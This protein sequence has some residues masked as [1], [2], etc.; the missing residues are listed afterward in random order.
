MSEEFLQPNWHV[1]LIHYPLGLLT[2]GILVELLAFLWRGSSV[3]AAARWMILIGALLCIPTITAGLYAFRDVVTPEP[4]SLDQQWHAVKAGSNWSAEQWHYMMR[5]IWFAAGGAALCIL[6]AF[7]WLSSSDRGRA[8]LHWPA[9]ILVL[10][11]FVLLNVGAWYSGE[12]VYRFGTSVAESTRPA[13]V[14]ET[15]EK[16]A[17]TTQPATAAAAVEETPRRYER[18]SQWRYYFPPVQVHVLLA[19]LTVAF[20]LGAMGATIRRWK[21]EAEVEAARSAVAAQRI[22]EPSPPQAASIVEAAARQPVVATPPVMIPVYPARIW[23]AA[24]LLGLLTA[25]AGLW[26]TG[27]WELKAV[28]DPLRDTAALE[29]M[30]RLFAHV[31]AG[32]SIVV[33]ALLLAVLTRMARRHRFFTTLLILLLIVAVGCQVWFGILLLFDS[34]A[35]PLTGFHAA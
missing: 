20:A 18:D 25:A 11:G 16:I 33:L 5:H 32:V 27:D 30:P 14:P 28:R 3:R 10:G 19:G 6:G 12:S 23:L 17:L 13:A 2:V 35:G 1:I 24:L 34:H 22:L 15:L 21:A 8:K 26:T 4:L 31:V 29:A 7:I 9:F